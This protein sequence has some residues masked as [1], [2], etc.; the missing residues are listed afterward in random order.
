MLGDR[1]LEDQCSRKILVVRGQITIFFADKESC[2]QRCVATHVRSP[3]KFLLQ[4]SHRQKD[5]LHLLLES[6]Q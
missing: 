1:V 4:N 5:H 6:P 3:L 2:S